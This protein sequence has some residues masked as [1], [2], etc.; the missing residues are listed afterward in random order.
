MTRENVINQKERKKVSRQSKQ[1][2]TK[3]NNRT[4]K[5]AA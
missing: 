2:N 1:T 5:Q 3:N 4:F